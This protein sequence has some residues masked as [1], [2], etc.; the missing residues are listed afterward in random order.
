MFSPIL[1]L[2][3]LNWLIYTVKIQ[4]I[5]KILISVDRTEQEQRA[6]QLIQWCKELL[7]HA[8]YAPNSIHFT[9]VH[10]WSRDQLGLVQILSS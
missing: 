5:T 3:F 6:S 1:H 4:I 7:Y 10:A 2:H 9:L 8:C